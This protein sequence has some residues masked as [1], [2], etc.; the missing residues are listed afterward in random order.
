M[1]R[2]RPATDVTAVNSPSGSVLVPIT[3]TRFTSRTATL[4]R[5]PQAP[6]LD[7][8][9]IQAGPSASFST[10]AA[11]TAPAAG[12]WEATRTTQQRT[13]PF[14]KNAADRVC[15]GSRP[16]TTSP[17]QD[18][19]WRHDCT[20]TGRS[21][22]PRSAMPTNAGD[23]GAQ[24]GHLRAAGVGALVVDARGAQVRQHVT[25]TSS[26]M[27][28]TTSSTALHRHL[29]AGGVERRALDLVGP[30]A[31]EVP[32]QDVVALLVHED[33]AAVAAVG[34]GRWRCCGTSP[35]ARCRAA[36]RA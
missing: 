20:G 33:H 9:R 36:F 28:S 31:L 27:S 12:S 24:R 21:S 3:W 5:L 4:S 15:R 18:A 32:A 11:A 30:G 16:G 23:V 35:T 7:A 13:P 8:R 14:S 29:V 34:A 2:A 10:T 1:S 25:R 22:G 17:N 6:S 26:V 19:N